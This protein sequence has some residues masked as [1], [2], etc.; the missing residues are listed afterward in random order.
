MSFGTKSSPPPSPAPLSTPTPTP[1]PSSDGDVEVVPQDAATE[2]A[3][4]STDESVLADT[5]SILYQFLIGDS[6]SMNARVGG[7]D[8]NPQQVDSYSTAWAP[9]GAVDPY[10]EIGR[11]SCRERV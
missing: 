6:S 2:A 9:N 8:M 3:T 7:W 10:V 5:D 1:T 11:A 4:D